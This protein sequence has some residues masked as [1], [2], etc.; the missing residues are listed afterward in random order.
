MMNKFDRRGFI[1][2]AMAL[3]AGGCTPV[4]EEGEKT[5]I[6]SESEYV[7]AILF[8]LSISFLE[9]MAEQGMA[10]RFA[11]AVLNRYFSDRSGLH[12]QI[13]LAQISGQEQALLW[14]GS[15]IEM[16]KKFPSPKQF[17]DFL[18]Q[19]SDPNQSLVYEGITSCLRHL[20]TDSRVRQ[21]QVKS[22]LLVVSD[23]V[24]FGPDVVGARKKMIEALQDY[25]KCGGVLG[26]Y[27]V[28]SKKAPLW[29][30][31]LRTKSGIREFRVESK[32]NEIPDLP[33]F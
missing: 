31:W 19:H 2:T 28:H 12:D 29:E 17:R 21:K 16:R 30:E 7:L 32:I 3:L 18:V 15:P 9:M 14:Q 13:I 26:L 25:G 8:D 20:M 10:F 1:G 22:A 24:E 23:M 4:A 11:L 33:N 5:F 6:E 27:Y